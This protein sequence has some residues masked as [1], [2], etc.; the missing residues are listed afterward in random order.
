MPLLDARR[1]PPLTFACTP[2][3]AQAYLYNDRRMSMRR[4]ALFLSMASVVAA[5]GGGGAGKGGSSGTPAPMPDDMP[6]AASTTGIYRGVGRLAA[7]D[8]LPFV[9]T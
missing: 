3:P 1:V 4:L 5:C 7:A 9:G 6:A 2:E 8:P